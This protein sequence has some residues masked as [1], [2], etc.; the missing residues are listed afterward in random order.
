MRGEKQQENVIRQVSPIERKI[1][2]LEVSQF[3]SYVI[4]D[5]PNSE[6]SYLY[7]GK[8]MFLTSKMDYL[9]Y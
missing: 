2:L 8:G 5:N 4:L 3:K 9:N 1:Y 7:L 6:H